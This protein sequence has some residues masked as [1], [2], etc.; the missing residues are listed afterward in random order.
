MSGLF[1]VATWPPPQFNPF[2]ASPDFPGCVSRCF[3]MSIMADGE[4]MIDHVDCM[5]FEDGALSCMMLA[6]D[7]VF[8]CL[9]VC[10]FVCVGMFM[11]VVDV[12]DVV[13]LTA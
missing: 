13:R 10:L 7:C 12:Q 6:V 1:Q 2:Y 8:V 11:F 5:N 3:Q 9:F 4:C